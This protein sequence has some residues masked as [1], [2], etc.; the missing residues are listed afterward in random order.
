MACIPEA[1]ETDD[2]ETLKSQVRALGKLNRE[3]LD[4]VEARKN[5][6]VVVGYKYV[7]DYNFRKMTDVFEGQPW[8]LKT[9]PFEKDVMRLIKEWTYEGDPLEPELIVR[10][11][12]LTLR[13]YEDVI[14]LVP[15]LQ[16]LAETY[17]TMMLDR[18][19]TRGGLR[20]ILTNMEKVQVALGCLHEKTV[21]APSF[22][23]DDLNV[24]QG[25]GKI[26][27][28]IRQVSR[29]IPSVVLDMEATHVC[30]EN[31]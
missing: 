5:E 17:S 16:E 11:D 15:A 14:R 25:M 3:T 20:T 18:L 10:R 27:E 24:K 19:E 28:G 23:E 13:K 22:V 9:T 7:L 21:N 4:I 6:K 26:V 29:T 1:S 12:D 31:D 30:G 8:A 2:F